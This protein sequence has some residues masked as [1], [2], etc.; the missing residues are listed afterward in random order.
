MRVHLGGIPI[1]PTFHPLEPW[2]AMNEPGLWLVQ[3]Y[4]APVAMLNFVLLGIPWFFLTPLTKDQVIGYCHRP[5]VWVLFILLLVVHEALHALAHP[6]HGSS[7]DT[8]LGIWPSRLVFYAHYDAEVTKSRFLVIILMPVLVLSL[9]PLA[10]CS[11]LGAAPALIAW[12]SILNALS[13]CVDVLG[14]M[15]VLY[16]VPNNAILRNLGWHTYWRPQL[17]A[18]RT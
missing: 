18:N 5:K 15:H 13:S 16:G 9:L 2:H 17:Q 14:A 1:N 4:A 3:L 12:L 11:I 7:P 6:G 10:L 8:V